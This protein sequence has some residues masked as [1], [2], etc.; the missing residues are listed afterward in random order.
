MNR[1]KSLEANLY[2]LYL[3]G[4]CVCLQ[5]VYFDT[6]WA[7]AANKNFF[8]VVH[9]RITVGRHSGSKIFKDIQKNVFVVFSLQKKSFFGKSKMSYCNQFTFL[10]VLQIFKKT[11]SC[12]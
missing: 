1:S 9:V 6:P 3:S 7:K 10:Q 4:T 8:L 2:N 11:E 5:E 12:F